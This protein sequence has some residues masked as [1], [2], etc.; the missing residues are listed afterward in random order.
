ML[1]YHEIF[2]EKI[3]QARQE[4]ER[5]IARAQLEQLGV[6][7]GT[8]EFLLEERHGPTLNAL[9]YANGTAPSITVGGV[10]LS[11]RPL[12]LLIDEES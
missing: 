8:I 10:K 12:L 4:R 1:N 11:D 7:A 5:G 3:E 9:L 2:R 6:K